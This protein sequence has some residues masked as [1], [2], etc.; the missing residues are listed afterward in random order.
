MDPASAMLLFVL[1]QAAEK[2]VG[3]AGGKIADSMGKPILEALEEKAKWLAGKDETAKRWEAFLQAFAETGK[4]LKA[5]GRHPELA[6]QIVEVLE[7]FDLKAL[8]DNQ[9]LDEL[10]IQLEKASL[11]SEKPD[12]YLLV[13]LFSR[14]L[15][16]QVSRAELSETVSDFVTV[17]QDVLFAQPAYQE[18]MFKRAQ[19]QALRKPRYDTRERYLAQ[20]IEYNENLDFVGIPELKDRQALR[21]EDVFIS[22]QTDVEAPDRERTPKITQEM[23]EKNIRAYIKD[24]KPKVVRRLSINQS[25]SESKKMSS[26]ATLALAKLP[27]SNTSC[28]PLPKTKRTK[29]V[30]LKHAYRF[31]FVCMITLPSGR[32]AARMAFLSPTI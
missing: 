30:W 4:K 19:W 32:N 2:A 3:Y 7:Q 14:V 26:L 5:Q 22:L 16:N 29:S 11:V 31:L 24:L 9:W 17:F 8:P 20:V 21:I 10:A 25:L 1:F 15:P 6:K 12:Q 23:V 27:F 13:E 18:A 28:L